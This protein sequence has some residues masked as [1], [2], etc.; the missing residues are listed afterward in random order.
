MLP[1]G[2]AVALPR[3]FRSG[4]IIVLYLERV[5]GAGILDGK[6]YAHH[7]AYLMST[8]TVSFIE[9]PTG[10]PDCAT[11]PGAGTACRGPGARKK[12]AALGSEDLRN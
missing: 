4:G 11:E 8:D 7:A 12:A 10:G 6:P 1:L 3:R 9:E 5:R 2:L